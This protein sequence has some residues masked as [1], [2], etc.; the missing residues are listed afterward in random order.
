MTSSFYL[1]SSGRSSVALPLQLRFA[2]KEVLESFLA[3]N[4]IF[5]APSNYVKSEDAKEG[6][7]TGDES[8]RPA[9]TIPE[10]SIS[11]EAKVNLTFGTGHAIT[12]RAEGVTILSTRVESS[13]NSVL[14]NTE[15]IIRVSRVLGDPIDSSGVK[16]NLEITA[17]FSERLAAEDETASALQVLTALS[18]GGFG[19]HEGT[20]S[21]RRVSVARLPPFA[22]HV[23][24]THALTI[25]V[26]SIPGPSMGQTFLAL[27]MAHS[28]THQQDLTITSIALH[29]GVTRQHDKSSSNG[30]SQLIVTD[31]SNFVKWGFA[32]QSDPQL[33][34]TL[35]PNEAFSTILTVDASEDS[36]SRRCCCPLSITAVIGKKDH[37]YHIVAATEAVWTTSRA[38][39]EPADTFRV[40]MN[41]QDGGECTVGAPLTV[42]MEISNLSAESRQLM[43]LV[44]NNNTTGRWSIVS[45]KEG[46]KFGFGG[47]DGEREL[48]AVDAALRLGEL[49]GHSSTKAKLRVIPLREGTLSIPNFQLVDSRTGKRYSCVHRLQ[50]VAASAK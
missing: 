36:L 6:G 47:P 46:Y 39:V 24:L 48:L 43:L 10:K 32:E 2:S 45:E 3:S 50:V 13:S 1:D 4:C 9:S 27:T 5:P 16:T 15:I 19:A 26:R 18:R 37:R 30:A 49:K 21:H 41:L 35:K 7:E 34:L 11:I 12:A 28:N 33:P 17:A 23:A 22:L 44:D 38:A 40:D 31:M 20:S 14:F 8:S 29:P 42:N 25:A